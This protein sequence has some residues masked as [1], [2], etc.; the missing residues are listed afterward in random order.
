MADMSVLSL[1]CPGKVNPLLPLRFGAA[2]CTSSAVTFPILDTRNVEQNQEMMYQQGHTHTPLYIVSLH[3][4]PFILHHILHSTQNY[5]TIFI[6]GLALLSIVIDRYR[7]G[8][9]LPYGTL[10]EN[11]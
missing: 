7:C 2:E 4:P 10:P 5:Q 3:P 1:T 11:I 9:T 8:L 6:Y